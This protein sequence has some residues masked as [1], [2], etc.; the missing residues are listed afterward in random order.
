MRSRVV[1]AFFFL[2]CA[3]LSAE[4]V[5]ITVLA[6]TDLHG[7]IYP[8][9]YYTGKPAD[10]GLAKIATL[11]RH[12]RQDNPNNILI[13][14]GDTIQGTPLEYVY[15]HWRETGKLPLDMSFTGAP[16]T[17]DPMM[18]AM[19]ALGY[20]AMVTGNHDFNF[21]LK[22]Q[23][24]ARRLARFP[25][26]SANTKTEPGA[27][28]SPGDA[29]PFEPWVVKTVAGVKVAIIGITTPGIPM[30]DPPEHYKGY[31]FEGGRAAAQDAVA[32]V[33]ATEHPDVVI[34]AAHA[35]LGP[36]S[37]NGP[38][39][40]MSENMIDAIATHVAGIDAIVFGHTHQSLPG[41]R[42]GSVLL[43]QPK[44]WGISLGRMDFKLSREGN[45][46]W[47]I[48]GKE[49]RLIPVA[50][51]T[52]PDP[53]ILDIAR[54]Y[55]ELAE[56]YLNTPVASAP[57]AMETKFSRIED[58]AAIDA[59]QQVQIDATHADVSFASSFNPNVHIAK[60]PVSVR[61]LAALYL[62][63]NELYMIA[64]NGSMV[65]EALENAAR[66]F[67]TCQADCRGETLLNQHVIGYN[68]D[69][70]EGVEYEID[71]K[72]PEGQRIKNL[73]W[74]GQPLADDQPLRIALNNHRAG[75]G[76][77]FSMFLGAKLLWESH[78]DIRDM[79][80]R[81]Y[82]EKGVLPARADNNWHVEPASARETLEHEALD[83][84]D[85]QSHINR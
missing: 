16:L 69:M 7:N 54:P 17:A 20:D 51:D 9:D 74:H 41:K 14:C 66:W 38:A 48:V 39:P 79:M 73:R 71:L 45:G 82:S 64:G 28:A 50:A 70:A 57:E 59:I 80:V 62:Y 22:N 81:Y 42:I 65:R 67:L 10:R 76:S 18:L 52:A 31:R 35:G 26:I 21:G 23:M 2:L 34:I 46:A 1:L 25:W 60:G 24:A 15:Q 63:D 84:A 78:E 37:A 72:Q 36:E 58:T 12:E 43:M 3:C 33:K 83:D 75:G 13:D 55:H 47:K 4:E 8:Y 85:R 40:E 68:F 6:T 5:T 29:Q 44:N 49:S 27:A 77:G 32:K 56:R 11:I 30:W 19:N 61:Q 53:Q